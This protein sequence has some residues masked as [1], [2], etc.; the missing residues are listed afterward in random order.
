[1]DAEGQVLGRLACRIATLLR[2]KDRPAFAPFRSMGDFVIVVNAEKVRLTGNKAKGKMYRWHTGYPGGLKQ[3]NAGEMRAR[4]PERL[5]EWA[6][7]GMLPGNRRRKLMMR[8][9]K[10]YGGADHPH[11]AQKPVRVRPGRR[12]RNVEVVA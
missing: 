5:I 2:G 9:L 3:M 8:H 1:M 10:I 12:P 4:R 11:A 7:W 6:V